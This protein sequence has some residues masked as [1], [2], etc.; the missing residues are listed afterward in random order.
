MEKRKNVDAILRVTKDSEFEKVFEEAQREYA[1]K[2][3]SKV[4]FAQRVL[5][6]EY[7]NIF[8]DSVDVFV[9]RSSLKL[10]DRDTG[11]EIAELEIADFRVEDLSYFISDIVSAFEDISD[12]LSL[13]FEVLETAGFDYSAYGYMMPE[14][15]FIERLKMNSESS[16][17]INLVLDAVTATAKYYTDTSRTSKSVIAYFPDDENVAKV[18]KDRNFLTVG[19]DELMIGITD[20]HDTEP[21]GFVPCVP[22]PMG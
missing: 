4:Q 11:D 9:R 2:G 18:M 20:V 6:G 12:D 17:D 5:S 8:D 22:L 1:R 21:S 14:L 3:I 15:V 7:G 16:A 10:A 13:L 19:N